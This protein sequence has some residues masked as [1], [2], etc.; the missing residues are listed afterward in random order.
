M[1]VIDLA[2]SVIFNCGMDFEYMFGQQVL[3]NIIMM[4][5]F[6]NR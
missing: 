1:S 6:F 5:G 2:A 4:S 3:P